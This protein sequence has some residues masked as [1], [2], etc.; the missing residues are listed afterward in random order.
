MQARKF[1]KF[2][3]V[4]FVLCERTDRHRPTHHSTLQLFPGRNKNAGREMVG[5]TSTDGFLAH[6]ALYRYRVFC[7]EQT[8]AR[9]CRPNA[10]LDK[11][12]DRFFVSRYSSLYTG[13]DIALFHPRL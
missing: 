13:S 4:V 1:V 2:G 6:R 5:A 9:C 12:V 11:T 3:R 8:S 7:T 10:I